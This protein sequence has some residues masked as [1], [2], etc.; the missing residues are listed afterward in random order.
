MKIGGRMKTLK[1]L[2]PLILLSG[3]IWG[4]TADGL[5][6][7]GRTIPP[8]QIASPLRAS[9]DGS[10]ANQEDHAKYQQASRDGNVYVCATS[11]TVTFQPGLSATM[12]PLTLYNPTGSNKSLVL[13]EDGLS[14]SGAQVAS[15]FSLAYSIT[16]LPTSLSTLQQQVPSVSN[17]SLSPWPGSY[18]ASPTGVC[19]SSATIPATPV[20]F[21]YVGS[22]TGAAITS[23]PMIDKPDGE[24]IVGPGMAVTFQATASI[25]S[26]AHF[27]WEEIPYP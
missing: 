8:G 3:M 26:Q 10:L 27:V 16:G 24:V 12:A 1:F 22:E 23:F 20:A 7:S 2:A 19:L 5:V 17:A 14:P 4:A 6:Q 9:P 15:I 11:M 21:R 18:R 13:L 25:A